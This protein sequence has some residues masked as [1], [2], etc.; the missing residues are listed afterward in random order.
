MKIDLS[1]KVYQFRYTVSGNGTGLVFPM[2]CFKHRC[3][4]LIVFL[5]VC[6]QCFMNSVLQCLSNTRQLLDYC[7]E[8]KY[9]T[10]INTT[11]SNMKGSLFKGESCFHFIKVLRN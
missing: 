11:T 4:Q 2:I 8:E 6:V 10:E 1:L 7:L 3:H 9:V 5:C